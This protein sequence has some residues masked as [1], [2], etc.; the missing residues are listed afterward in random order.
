MFD[1]HYR[2]DHKRGLMLDDT[3]PNSLDT[4]HDLLW[5]VSQYCAPVSSGNH[6]PIL[7]WCAVCSLDATG[8]QDADA[9]RLVKET[10]ASRPRCYGEEA[11]RKTC[12]LRN[13][14]ELQ[15]C[16]F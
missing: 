12:F 2:P 16:L 1:Q 10:R 8:R 13:E 3:L 9:H 5:E 7:I 6:I 11:A 15:S 14:P 4:N